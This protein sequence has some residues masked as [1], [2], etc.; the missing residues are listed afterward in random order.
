MKKRIF[1]VISVMVLFVLTLA[2]FKIVTQKEDA[3]LNVGYSIESLDHAPIMII[4]DIN[5][6]DKYG[7][8]VNLIPLKGG[9]EVREA[10][11][12]GKIDF[13]LGGVGHFLIPIAKGAPVKII[14]FL[15]ESPTQIF[16][17]PDKTVTKFSDISG[18]NVASRI[19][20]SSY[21]I[22]RFILKKEGIDTNTINFLDI[23]KT[24]TPI[25]LMNKKIVDLALAG[26]GEEPLYYKAGAVLFE[27]WVNKGYANEPFPKSVIA[28]NTDFSEKNVDDVSNFILAIIDA[29]KYIKEHPNDAA[30]IIAKHIKKGSA[31]AVDYSPED[32]INSWRVTKYVLWKD[33]NVL[34]EFSKL[35][36]ELGNTP[37]ELSKEQ[38][39]DLRFEEVLKN[40][41]AEIYQSNN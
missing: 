11:A 27:D 37:K 25:A 19:G 5:L 41:Q 3:I 22:F 2:I 12:L 4:A 28:V 17:R 40:G 33:P 38:I 1:V 36:K 10:L 23:D 32:I 21:L 30:E 14:S 7:I 39:F 31:G 20:G 16:V 13:G 35:S 6:S 29:E 26:D 8:K 18:K 15:T 24:I 9:K 34:V